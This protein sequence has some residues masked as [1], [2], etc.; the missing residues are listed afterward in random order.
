[1]V[2]DDGEI[3]LRN[4]DFYTPTTIRKMKD[5]LPLGMGVFQKQY[6]WFFNIRHW[7]EGEL[8]EYGYREHVITKDETMEY[9]NGMVIK[10][11]ESVNYD[12]RLWDEYG[13]SNA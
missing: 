6:Q 5:Y 4:C 9:R 12:Q 2:V 7:E 10:L 13:S 3:Q 1:M 11:D 8:S